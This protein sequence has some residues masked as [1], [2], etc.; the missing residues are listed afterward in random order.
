MV[1]L[2]RFQFRCYYFDQ[3]I[4]K[5]PNGVAELSKISYFCSDSLCYK[6]FE[7]FLQDAQDGKCVL[8]QSTGFRDKNGKLIFEGDLLAFAVLKDGVYE[9]QW[10]KDILVCKPLN[11]DN[12]DCADSDFMISNFCYKDSAVEIVGNIYDNGNLLDK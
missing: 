2:D 5:V 12:L 10:E 6:S 4:V 7:S 9:V 3:E 8:M 11:N 1:N